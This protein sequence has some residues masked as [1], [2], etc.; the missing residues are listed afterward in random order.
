MDEGKA[1]PP[2]PEVSL[3]T[4]NLSMWKGGNKAPGNSGKVSLPQR[5]LFSDGW[6]FPLRLFRGRSCQSYQ[7]LRQF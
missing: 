3:R 2:K 1:D 5:K 7:A 6:G 4:Q